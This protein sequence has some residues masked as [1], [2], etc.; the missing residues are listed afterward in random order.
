MSLPS[1]FSADFGFAAKSSGESHVFTLHPQEAALL[2]PYTVASR[3]ESFYLG[4]W[5]AHD[6]LKQ[7]ARDDA[8]ILQ[9]NH[10]AP[11]WPQGIVGSIS[12]T[13]DLA[14][15]AVANIQQCAG[16]GIDIEDCERR[17]EWDVARRICDP[18]ELSWVTGSDEDRW[19]RFFALFSAK[20]TVFKAFFPLHH[21]FL[22]FHDAHLDW[23]ERRQRFAGC[24]RK[25]ASP[26]YRAGYEFSVDCQHHGK[27]VMTSLAIF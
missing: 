19:Q 12:H 9:N 2:P 22:D 25:D 1:P 24:L 26:H 21:V 3:R 14:V 20:E 17:V 4:R 16:I 13:D 8:P 18:Q 6:A 5:A 7:L 23:D 10:R 11:L 15:A 27:Y